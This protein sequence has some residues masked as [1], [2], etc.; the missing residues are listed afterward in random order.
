MNYQK[1]PEDIDFQ[2]YWLIFKFHWRPSILVFA[3]TVIAALITALSKEEIFQASGKVKFKK[4][5]TSS[6]LVTEV[7]EKIGQLEA[8]N[9][10]NNP[11]DTEAEV[12]RSYEVVSQTIKELNLSDDDNEPLTYQDFLKALDLKNIPGTDVLLVSYKSSDP[13]EAKQ[14]VDQLMAAYLENNVL[15]NRV[16]AA[17]ARKFINEQLP[18]TEQALLE[19]EANL[20]SFKEKYNIVNLTTESELKVSQISELNNTIKQKQALLERLSSRIVNLES[21]L[22]FSAEAVIAL[23]DVSDSEAI[24]LTI[25]QLQEVKN[26][27]AK[28]QSRFSNQNPVV[29]NLEEEK[30]SLEALLRKQIGTHLSQQTRLLE[31]FFQTG[32]IQKNLAEQLVNT[33]VE[34]QEV[35]KEIASLKQN[36]AEYREKT[37]KI[38][39][40]EQIQRDLQRKLDAAQSAYQA[41][42][43]NLQQVLIAENQNV[44]NAQIINSAIVSEYPVSTSKKLILAM[45]IALGG[46]LSVITAF[47]LEIR[48]CSVKTSKELKNLLDFTMLGIIPSSQKKALLPRVEWVAPERQIIDAP[49]SITA[50]AY[51]M[52]QANLKFLCPDKNIKVV[53]VTS[54]LPKEGKSTVSAN[55]AAVLAQQGNKVLLIDAHLHSPQQ[56]HIWELTNQVGL[57]NVI[58]TRDKLSNAI[59]LVTSNLS[60]LPSGIDHP[61]PLSLLES[62][63]MDLF[64]ESIKEDYDYIIIDTPPLLLFADALILSKIAD[65]VLLVARPGVINRENVKAAEEL[66]QKYNQNVLGLVA[67]GVIVENE[68]D[69]YFHYA[70]SYYQDDSKTVKSLP[71]VKETRQ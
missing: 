38:P 21:K 23:N 39:E 3:I 44:G 16:E 12:I 4:S 47:I 61:N 59:K 46:I 6:A 69:S 32:D 10:Q 58:F 68:P 35:V 71:E 1:H 30:A 18:K 66:L 2:K 15:F 64:I 60:V 48:D 20:R 31:K 19:A 27:L 7:G 11:L 45:G 55:L 63:Q 52:F 40:F 62:K 70:K 22:G 28:E 29:I 56:H 26:R 14:I 25:T 41:L 42:L 34:R 8:L 24:Q 37:S 51:K 67:N 65:G 54:S 33:E 57:S 17:A 13:Q 36:I 43:N 5:N 49:K 50:E 53:A 9:F